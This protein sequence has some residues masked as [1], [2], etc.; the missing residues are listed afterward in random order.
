M[1]ALEEHGQQIAAIE[2][3]FAGWEAWVSLDSWWHA[4]NPGRDPVMVHAESPEE[5][6]EQI[7]RIA[8]Q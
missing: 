7:R 8:V 2:A 3:E 1:S 6:Y 4:R 5:L